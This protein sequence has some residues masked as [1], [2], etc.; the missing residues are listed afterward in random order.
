MK[1]KYKH[2]EFE[3]RTKRKNRKTEIADCYNHSGEF[4]GCIKW[5]SAWRQYCWFQA[6][7][8]VMAKSCLDDVSHFIKQLMDARKS[9]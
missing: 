3:V 8:I 2:I 5:Y 6:E 1:T 4:L 7:D 9:T